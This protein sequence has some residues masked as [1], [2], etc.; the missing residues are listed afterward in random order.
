MHLEIPVRGFCGVTLR[1]RSAVGNAVQRTAQHGAARCAGYIELPAQARRAKNWRTAV[2]TP[3]SRV[4]RPPETSCT[5]IVASRVATAVRQMSSHQ[6]LARL[7][8]GGIEWP[9]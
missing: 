6:S 8:E 2:A 9:R 1:V 4:L 5:P 7:P 3:V